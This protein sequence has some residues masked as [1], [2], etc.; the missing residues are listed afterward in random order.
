MK[1]R[2]KSIKSIKRA[3][4]VGVVAVVAVLAVVGYSNM[5]IHEVVNTGNIYHDE[6]QN[7]ECYMYTCTDRPPLLSSSNISKGTIVL[8]G[9]IDTMVTISKHNIT[10]ERY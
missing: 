9:G 3:I 1:L 6:I 7:T 4:V 5:S 8:I 2:I 10:I